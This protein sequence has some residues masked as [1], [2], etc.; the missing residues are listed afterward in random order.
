MTGRDTP[1][2]SIA[3]AAASLH[4]LAA[5]VHGFDHLLIPVEILWWQGLVVAVSVFGGPLVGLFLLLSNR[6]ALGGA[7][8]A[9][10]L[11]AAFGFEL[12]AHVLASDSWNPDY[13]GAVVDAESRFA[14]T[15][16]VALLTDALGA[17][18]GTLCWTGER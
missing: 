7:V 8:L 2:V 11:G 9:L 15:A 16:A 10:S 3:V 12:F 6:R 1:L 18:A 17:V 14:T 4:V 13:V 5:G